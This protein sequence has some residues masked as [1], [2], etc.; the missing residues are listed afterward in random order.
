MAF[1]KAIH[2]T[3]SRIGQKVSDPEE[4]GMNGTN[5]GRA[6]TMFLGQSYHMQERKKGVNIRFSGN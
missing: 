5:V 2:Q 1:S 3:D 6:K 4:T